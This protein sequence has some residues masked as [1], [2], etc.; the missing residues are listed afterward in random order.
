MRR[1]LIAI[2]ALLAAVLVWSQLAEVQRVIATLQRGNLFWLALAVLVQQ[3]WLLNTALTYRAI[4]RLLDMPI[5]LRHLLPLVVTNNFINVV[6]PSGGVGGIAL[7]INDARR[8]NLSTPRVTIAGVLFVLFDYFGFLCVLALGL[9]VL[10]RRGHLNAAEIAAAAILFAT[11]AA[12]ASL[13][14]L[15][16]RSAHALERVLVWGAR[17]INRALLPLLRRPYLSETR[18]HTFAA[19]AAEGLRA[20]RTDWRAYL[21]PAAF[22]LAGKALLITI[23]F[24]TFLAFEQ[25]FSVGTLIAGFSIA[26]LF[27]IVSPTPSGMGVVETVLPPALT[28]LRVPAGAALIITLAYRGLTFWLP[29]GYGFLTLRWLEQR[30]GQPL[31]PPP[32]P[33]VQ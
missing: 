19:E 5:T 25:P 28:A 9:L 3:I 27:M 16:A 6:T 1:L 23:L 10:F 18:A 13:L 31:E 32:A 2:V 33:G 4:Y 29:F 14:A 15:G 21:L 26:W 12:L 8:A 22:S 30:W 17:A 11:A 20:L 7:F 24:L